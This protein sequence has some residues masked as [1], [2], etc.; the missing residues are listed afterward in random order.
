MEFSIPYIFAFFIVVLIIYLFIR[1][2]KKYS[3]K[4]S[5]EVGKE[6]IFKKEINKQVNNLLNVPEEEDIEEVDKQLVNLFRK[7]NWSNN[8][9]IVPQRSG[10]TYV[11]SKQALQTLVDQILQNAGRPLIH[12]FWLRIFIG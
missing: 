12:V 11:N 2:N 5:Q 8:E 6:V 10:F 1:L 4:P 3:I 9:N 7:F